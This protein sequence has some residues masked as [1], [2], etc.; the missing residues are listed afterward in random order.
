MPA[1]QVEAGV[2]QLARQSAEAAR[3]HALVAGDRLGRAARAVVEARV[4]RADAG[5]ALAA[6]ARVAA[7]ADAAERGGGGGAGGG[8]VVARRS[9]DARSTGAGIVLALT[10]LAAVAAQTHADALPTG[11][12]RH[13]ARA[14][15][16]T[17]LV[18]VARAV[19][20]HGHQQRGPAGVMAPVPRAAL[21]APARVRRPTDTREA[22]AVVV[23]LADAAVTAWAA[24]ARR[25][26]TLAV[27]A[28]EAGRTA[29]AAGRRT[30]AG[31]SVEADDGAAP[32]H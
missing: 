12:A 7:P 25:H 11:A 26:T 14:A 23:R 10:P 22:G 18:V 19:A 20:A 2:A 13:E 4:G 30:R 31:G 28:L 15:V 9:V 17:V 32:A 8:R 27:R 3:T 6:C 5:R 16:E 21:A 1:R 24:A 29:A